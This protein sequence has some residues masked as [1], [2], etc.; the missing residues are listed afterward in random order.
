MSS[1]KKLAPQIVHIPGRPG[2]DGYGVKTNGK[3]V[4]LEGAELEKIR[5]KLEKTERKQKMWKKI[6]G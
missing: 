3:V 6:K 2:E 4:Q 5:K 1:K